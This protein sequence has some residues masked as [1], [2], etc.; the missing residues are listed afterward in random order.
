MKLAIMQ[1]YFL[2]YIGYFQ[3]MHAVDRFV[4][5]DNIKYTKKGWINR[6]RLLING[7]DDFFTVPIQNASDSLDVKDRTLAK[8][9][10]RS[11]LLNRF[12]EAYRKAPYSREVLPLLEEIISNQEISLFGFLFNSICC[13]NRVIS[14]RTDIVISSSIDVDHG[15]R[16]QEKVI[17]LCRTLGAT[18]YINLIGGM[19]LYSKAEFEK[20]GIKLN[21]LKSKLVEY[22]Q[23]QNDFV[24]WLSIIDVLMFNGM[25]RT[26]RML[27]DWV[28]L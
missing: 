22:A 1:P 25:E 18:Q 6:N 5:Y 16:G 26:K 15:L 19:T 23:F 20:N 24:P 4:I 8:E 11:K 27:D 12:K 10:D 21:F 13:I 28:L 3:L 17:S 7:A 2:P 9:F 14:V